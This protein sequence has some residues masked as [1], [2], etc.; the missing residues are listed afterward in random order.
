MGGYS[1]CIFPS[2]QSNPLYSFLYP[3]LYLQGVLCH[4]MYISFLPQGIW[5]QVLVFCLSSSY[6]F[7]SSRLS[8]LPIPPAISSFLFRMSGIYQT[9]VSLLLCSMKLNRTT[10]LCLS[11]PSSMRDPSFMVSSVT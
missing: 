8:Y 4:P 2:I 10:S 9:L 7:Q 3:L 6:C 1:F 5:H 11:V